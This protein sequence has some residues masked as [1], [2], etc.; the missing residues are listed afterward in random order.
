MNVLQV[1]QLYS[2]VTFLSSFH[3]TLYSGLCIAF[4]S[5]IRNDISQGTDAE[6]IQKQTQFA[7][8]IADVLRKNVVQGTRVQAPEESG[9]DGV[10]RK[11]QYFAFNNISF[12]FF[13]NSSDQGYGTGRQRV[14]KES[15]TRRI[16]SQCTP[17]REG[18]ASKVSTD[19]S[20][21]EY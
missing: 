1:I 17:E 16:R 11:P 2:K 14:N 8:E 3:N 6:S 21:T 5:K 9:G 13:R 19:F 18:A 12:I 4:R 10:Y 7:R 15:S 20:A